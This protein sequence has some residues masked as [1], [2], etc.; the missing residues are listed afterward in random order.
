MRSFIY[1]LLLAVTFVFVAAAPVDQQQPQVRR[2]Y[3]DEGVVD[4]IS[5]EKRD[6]ETD[7]SKRGFF[8]YFS[9]IGSQFS[10]N[11]LNV[12]KSYFGWGASTSVSTG[13]GSGSTGSS[14]S[15]SSGSG[16]TGSGDDCDD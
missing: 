7:V 4:S 15:G 5:F 12:F 2:Y 11:F 14:G 6:D 10:T 9:N 3:A 8:D 16:S 1:L 13:S